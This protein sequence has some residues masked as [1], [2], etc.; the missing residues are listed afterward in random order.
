MKVIVQACIMGLSTLCFCWNVQAQQTTSECVELGAQV[1]NDWTLADAGGSGVPAGVENTDYINCH[2]CHGWD[3]RGLQG[4]QVRAER[5]ESRPNT[6]AGDGDGRSRAI[7][8]GSVTASQV[9]HAGS[10]RSFTEGKASWVPLQP[11]PTADNIADHARGYTLGNQHPD[12]SAVLTPNQ[13]DCVVEFLNAPDGDPD[14]YFAAIYPDQNPVLYLPVESADP[15]VGEAFFEINCEDC[16]TLT[17]VLAYLDE[18]GRPSE[19]SH[20]ARWGIPDSEMTRA[21]M[22]D[23]DAADV[24]DLMSFLLEESDALFSLNSGLTGTWWNGPSRNGE[25]LLIELAWSNDQL[26]LFATLYT[27]DSNGNQ[28]W[29]IAQG[30]ATDNLAEVEVFITEGPSWGE[31]Y[32]PDDFRAISWGIAS[33]MFT[34]CESGTLSL[35]PNA[36][37]LQMGFSPLAYDLRRDL[38][39]SGIACPTPAAGPESAQK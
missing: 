35:V 1:F 33:F 10:G 6:G 26:Y 20:L 2:S 18:D 27:Y 37:M 36:E 3:R 30:P 9:L 21:A 17:S 34:S 29:L 5:S 22:G 14:R 28:V 4:G 19:L 25:G 24:A 31:G 12:Y 13:V 38:L 23:P 7:V 8:T 39:T 15:V 11:N 16:H 32:D